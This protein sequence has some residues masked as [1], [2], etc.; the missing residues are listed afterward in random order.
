[1][2]LHRWSLPSRAFARGKPSAEDPKQPTKSSTIHIGQPGMLRRGD[3][4]AAFGALFENAENRRADSNL[5]DTRRGPDGLRPLASR[6]E[7]VPHIVNRKSSHVQELQD[8]TPGGLDDVSA[9]NGGKPDIATRDPVVHRL[10]G[11]LSPMHGV[12]GRT[13]LTSQQQDE[14]R[15]IRS[16]SLSSSTDESREETQE[17]DLPKLIEST[18]SLNRV[19]SASSSYPSEGIRSPNDLGRSPEPTVYTQHLV[20]DLSRYGEYLSQGSCYTPNMSANEMPGRDQGVD[21]NIGEGLPAN[22]ETSDT[23]Y[24]ADSEDRGHERRLSTIPS[25]TVIDMKDTTISQSHSGGD[26]SPEKHP[27]NQNS[28]PLG[29]FMVPILHDQ[30]SRAEMEVSHMAMRGPRRTSTSEDYD[31]YRISNVGSTDRL[32]PSTDTAS[33]SPTTIRR[34]SQ[35]ETS[36]KMPTS[37]LHHSRRSVAGEGS[38][39]HSVGSELPKLSFATRNMSSITLVH[40]LQKF[41]FK[42]WVKKVCLQTKVRFEHDSKP[43]SSS[44]VLHGRKSTPKKSRATKKKHFRRKKKTIFP[45]WH[46]SK[47]NLTTRK[48][49]KKQKKAALKLFDSMQAKKSL[50]F[51][52]TIRTEANGTISLRRTQSCPAEIGL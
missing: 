12:F 34:H 41:K 31:C 17:K 21:H 24:E 46:P 35:A 51:P 45:L 33:T 16:F 49:T 2:S 13:P 48:F 14:P 25:S 6:A 4:S 15:K 26:L 30:S 44:T 29:G 50:Q 27:G 47:T 3:L 40:R 1:M 36:Q 43:T 38:A 18:Y 37:T 7:N 20:S 52:V 10:Q 42:K 9:N 39:S 5:E 23:G 32:R 8:T 11:P 22:G 28:S 19:R